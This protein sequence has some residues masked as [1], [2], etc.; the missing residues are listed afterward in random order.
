MAD[1][2]L[3]GHFS[4]INAPTIDSSS[5]PLTGHFG[6]F[7]EPSTPSISPTYQAPT[8]KDYAAIF[9]ESAA[10]TIAGAAT[11]AGANDT[12]DYWRQK[13]KDWG[14]S[15][16]PDARA[17][18]EANLGS[19]RWQEHPFS[20]FALNAIAQAP[21][22]AAIGGAEAIGG[23]FAA[24]GMGAAV[25]GAG[26]ADALAESVHNASPEELGPHYQQLVGSGMSDHDARQQI[27]Q[28]AL[29]DSHATEF[30][31]ALGAGY[32]VLGPIG[33]IARGPMAGAGIKNM[34]GRM[35]I[36]NVEAGLIGGV[37]DLGTNLA[38]NQ[39][40]GE[41]GLPQTSTEDMLWSAGKQ[42]L[43]QGAFGT[44]GGLHRGE[45]EPIPPKPGPWANA[46]IGPTQPHYMRE[47]PD[48]SSTQAKES[49]IEFPHPP[50]G[51]ENEG[52][53]VGA[54]P[55]PEMPATTPEQSR[56]SLMTQLQD[57]EELRGG[58][59]GR[60]GGGSG[61][62]SGGKDVSQERSQ[63]PSAPL[64]SAQA[65][66]VMP[67]EGPVRTDAEKKSQAQA[68][69]EKPVAGENVSIRSSREGRTKPAAG[70]DFGRAEDT[71]QG[72]PS[73]PSS[74][75]NADQTIAL[76][77]SLE[78]QPPTIDSRL[79]KAMESLQR[80]P[81]DQQV[82]FIQNL[83]EQGGEHSNAIADML[84][85]VNNVNR[86]RAQD[87]SVDNL[88]RQPVINARAPSEPADGNEP[89]EATP[90]P[91]PPPE[92][93]PA[94]VPAPAITPSTPAL[95]ASPAPE[96]QKPIVQPKPV[97]ITLQET[98]GVAAR[99]H[100]ALQEEPVHE[101]KGGHVP[102][103]Q[104]K[105]RKTN[106]D[107]ADKI[108]NDH[109]PPAGKYNPEA[110]SL[111]PDSQ[112]GKG[113]LVA[114]RARLT[115][116]INQAEKEK[117][118]IPK[119]FREVG[120]GRTNHSPS[121]VLLDEARRFLDYTKGKLEEKDRIEA[122]EQF[123]SREAMLRKGEYGDILK[124]R[125]AQAER[126]KSAKGE[127]PQTGE[128]TVESE[129]LEA[130]A[131][132]KEGQLSIVPKRLPTPYEELVHKERLAEA[133]ERLDAILKKYSDALKVAGKVDPE[134]LEELKANANE[135]IKAM[136]ELGFDAPAVYKSSDVYKH[137]MEAPK[138]ELEQ[139]ELKVS[140][141]REGA[142]KG[143]E[144]SATPN[145]IITIRDALKKIIYSEYHPAF[146]GMMKILVNKL[147]DLVGDMPVYIF[148]SKEWHKFMDPQDQGGYDSKFKHVIIHQDYLDGH[149]PLHEAFH[150][151]TVYAYEHFPEF[152]KLVDALYNEVSSSPRAIFTRDTSY[153]FSHPIE[154]L[155]EMMSNPAVQNAFKN[156]YISPELAK[157]LDIPNW[158]KASMFSTIID[159]LRS[160][161]GFDPKYTNVM[162][163]AASLG[164]H[165]MHKQFPSE[166]ARYDKQLR[167]AGPTIDSQ[168]GVY[169][170]ASSFYHDQIPKQ[171]ED[172]IDSIRDHLKNEP[173]GFRLKLQDWF[174]TPREMGVALEQKG[175]FQ[176]KD[177]KPG[178]FR[179]WLEHMSQQGYERT[180]Y[181]KKH[182][183]VAKSI[184]KLAIKK[185]QE[186]TKLVDLL[187][188]AARHG[189]HPD[190]PLFE[191]KNA[192][193]RLT[194]N[195]HWEA[196]A[197]H[198]ED[199]T[200]YQAMEPGTQKVFRDIRDKM[201]EIH[202]ADMT[203]ARDS[204]IKT[205]RK[206]AK[207]QGED[208]LKV[209]EKVAKDQELTAKEEEEHGNDPYLQDIFSYNRMINKDDSFFYF[210]MKRT[211]WKYAITGTHEYQAPAGARNDS[212][213]PHRWIFD[214]HQ[215]AY[216][217]TANVGLPSY[218]ESKYYFD[219][220]NGE[221]E[222]VSGTEVRQ[223]PQGTNITPKKEIHVV[224]D[225]EHTEFANSMTEGENIR[226]VMRQQGVKDISGVMPVKGQSLKRYGFYGPQVEAMKNRVDKLEHLDP[227]E[228]KAAQDA[229]E[230]AA[231]ASMRGNYLP[232][233]LLPRRRVM[234]TDNID[235]IKSFW[236]RIR[237]SANF[238]TMANH[239]F[240]IDEALKSMKE[241]VDSK[242]THAD[243]TELNHFYNM[244]EDRTMNF[245]A[246]A[247]D[248]VNMS[249]LMHH[250][251][252][253]AV[254]KYLA[255]PA[256]L[257]YHQLHVPLVVIPS[258]AKHIG[259]FPAFR[260]ALKTYRQMLGGMPVIGKGI[261]GGWE[262]A[263]SYDKEP[264]DFVEALMS[265]LKK[266]G[267]TE[268][269]LRAMQY[270]VENDI[271]HHT[272]INF[273][274]YFQGMSAI[275]RFEQ[276]AMGVSSEIIGSA[277]AVNRFNSM[278][279]FYRAARDKMGIKNEDEAFRWAADRV[280]ET[281]GQ[282]TAF[283]RVGLMRSPNV[284]AVMQF[285]S[286]PLI[287]MKT[288][289]K[290]L[291]NSLRWGASTNE[292]MDAVKTLAGL[293]GASMAISG[294]QG[295][296]P[297]PI[298]DLNNLASALGLTNT[299]DQYEDKLREYVADNM[300]T[301]AATY[302]MNGVIGGGLGVDLTHR[303]GIS[304]LTGLARIQVTKPQDLE[305]AMFKFLAGV[306][307][308]IFGDG[309]DGANAMET[310][311]LQGALRAFL[312]RVITDP[313]K[314]YQMYNQGVTTRAGKVI[315]AP[316]GLPDTL[317]QAVGLAPLTASHAREARYLIGEERSEE[318]KEHTRIKELY[319]SGK[320]GDAIREMN[321]FNQGRPNEPLK[322]SDLERAQKET[323][324]KKV[325]GYDVTKKH[326]QEYEKKARVY[327][328]PTS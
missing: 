202:K 262:R 196:I 199:A 102:A 325:L 194:N 234:G 43:E 116:M 153:A 33:K 61:K 169:K 326:K 67:S 132:K 104:E 267:G 112:G 91:A 209:F 164:E 261:K 40:Y 66:P 134:H 89:L 72:S 107:K 219:K 28:D 68:R 128:K 38:L 3:A 302:V 75:V 13:A 84:T 215:D 17:N 227:S 183:D 126:V 174:G 39:A 260:M 82:R 161:L 24:A 121:V 162:E 269:E 129:K 246:D 167:K 221:R 117:V 29:R 23:P 197:G 69:H 87:S 226:D 175:H 168:E 149:T 324:K 284:R 95:R 42:A 303:G 71:E 90:L 32:G 273:S 2:P 272:G 296:V 22:L 122:A 138:E 313:I 312:P 97:D 187:L 105:T 10:H 94:P 53:G 120:E 291:Y 230:H 285:K 83:R 54:T 232:Q 242:R 62:E 201:Q 58:I 286:F 155:T 224:V 280:A 223:T 278:L 109:Q 218:R 88:Q 5:D 73:I 236:D 186:F 113:A 139:G 245:A 274:S 178:P 250:V 264:T 52:F 289:T 18:Y 114:L 9:G 49:G 100:Q 130:L 41:V 288:I 241:E 248:D 189:A 8:T 214:N 123:L 211:A 287:L 297:E 93:G 259:W 222:Y 298:E 270:A 37:Q 247:L 51:T 182:L 210:P 150:A 307:G 4:A 238:Q 158:R 310:G 35:T 316:L 299:W 135:A 115:S 213:D 50:S 56:Q 14:D 320:K 193:L 204:L 45:K 144:T 30:A 63:T 281:Q 11:Y 283:N 244:I 305:N 195:N 308:S 212:K 171:M 257:A 78:N 253:L 328:V 192:F 157:I 255:S 200:K 263:M 151:A 1:D 27:T 160:I 243:A 154:M 207:T 228:R 46:P 152:G 165:M 317:R 314:A 64:R 327:G 318:Q 148:D 275:E 145:R 48:W 180:Q 141:S 203:A 127:I 81:Q 295:A 177:G 137:L 225:P 34:L 25:Y 59:G 277:D 146:R 173:R 106:N 125:S 271:L 111:L 293:M 166:A 292:R 86:D 268:D 99:I 79:Q 304:N 216:D 239:R 19:K 181:L 198:P 290:A 315:S 133:K 65:A 279:M 60:G 124:E 311:D 70:R 15:V 309:I 276:R 31:A 142:A 147:S 252:S 16:S 108:V 92:S 256:F 55:T 237:A 321:K 110:T 319:T 266:H 254:I 265:E 98:K 282:F 74:P 179:Q 205:Y 190:D 208:F 36:S 85:Q 258:L 170:K 322:L 21:Q 7:A 176:G 143:A 140:D 233:N 136:E 191:G 96:P 76:Q 249:R 251:Q 44:L 294:V 300:G 220:P 131:E 184:A 163:A 6:A 217:F 57:L 206:Y 12:A 26:A 20:Q 159:K 301:D 229:I 118:S 80:L 235:V 47:L 119:S 172:S 188:S 306:P 77:S 103:W 156:I 231:I 240:E 323:A 185:P 101:I